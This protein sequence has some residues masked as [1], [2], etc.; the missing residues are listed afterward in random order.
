MPLIHF[1]LWD[2]NKQI[3]GGNH[4]LLSYY[5]LIWLFIFAW[6]EMYRDV[7]IYEII[8]HI[9]LTTA[10]SLSGYNDIISTK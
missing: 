5:T 9:A 7:W 3:K 4:I 1:K 6:I 10:G 2:N 8:P